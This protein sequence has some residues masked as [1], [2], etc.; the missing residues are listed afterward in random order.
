VDVV[1]FGFGFLFF[2]LALSI[3]HLAGQIWALID[4]LRREDPQ[5]VGNSRVLW[6]LI[7]IFIPFGWLGYLV[8]G[9]R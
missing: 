7:V 2:T 3:V 9:R 6:A 4:L 5:V 1:G 8:A